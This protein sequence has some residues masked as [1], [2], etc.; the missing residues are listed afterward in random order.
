MTAQNI[1]PGSNNPTLS[2]ALN[3]KLSFKNCL[4]NLMECWGEKSHEQMMMVDGWMGGENTVAGNACLSRWSI[5]LSVC[6][7]EQPAQPN[8]SEGS[9]SG[10]RRKL[11]S[12]D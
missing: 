7:R 9:A 11:G 10:P 5:Q 8:H 1:S 6:R 12:H 3:R 2:P 4:E